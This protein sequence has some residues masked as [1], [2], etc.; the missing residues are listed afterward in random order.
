MH[1]SMSLYWQ[2]LE[3]TL[4]QKVFIQKTPSIKKKNKISFI[5]LYSI[6]L[7]KPAGYM[8]LKT[9]PQRGS[10]RHT[11]QN[12]F[13]Y[14]YPIYT[15]HQHPSPI[16]HG[17]HTHSGKQALGAP[18][19]LGEL[20]HLS[21]LSPITLRTEQVLRPS[22]KGPQVR[23]ENKERKLWRQPWKLGARREPNK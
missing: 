11:I 6:S 10:G 21:R 17:T 18:A 8:L 14:I 2:H 23:G 13:S 12:W 1:V 3:T 16:T 20:Q 22:P 9:Q 7:I 5:P 4:R 19:A 15:N